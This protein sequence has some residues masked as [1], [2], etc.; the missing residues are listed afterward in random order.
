MGIWSYIFPHKSLGNLSQSCGLHTQRCK[1]S[2]KILTLCQCIQSIS[3]SDCHRFFWGTWCDIVV[4]KPCPNYADIL[5]V[6]QRLRTD[7]T[8]KIMAAVRSKIKDR[9]FTNLLQSILGSQSTTTSEGIETLSTTGTISDA[10]ST[11]GG[12]NL[13][14]HRRGLLMRWVKL[15][16]L[17]SLVLRKLVWWNYH[18]TD[19]YWVIGCR[20]TTLPPVL[21]SGKLKSRNYPTRIT[22]EKNSHL[23]NEKGGSD[24]IQDTLGL[25]SQVNPFVIIADWY[26]GVS[27]GTEWHL[28]KSTQ[29]LVFGLQPIVNISSHNIGAK[30]C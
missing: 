4:D 28:S 29:I 27:K 18:C 7:D 26:R 9:E 20:R 5:N 30:P 11:A 21:T 8:G 1:K 6:G 22:V 16:H 15:E 17:D 10:L 23:I 24:Y 3:Q 13:T 2:T 19:H 12:V 14:R 25:V